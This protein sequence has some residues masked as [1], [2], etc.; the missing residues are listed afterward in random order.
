MKKKI[1]VRVVVDGGVA[2]VDVLTDGVVVEVRDYDD[3]GDCD[4][5]SEVVSSKKDPD[6]DEYDC[7]EG[8]AF[9]GSVF[10]KDAD[11][12]VCRRYF[13]EYSPPPAESQPAGEES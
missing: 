2:Y 3:G 4:Y 10:V 1:D 13:E 8:R 6:F 7:S 11:G 5:D 12:D 9:A